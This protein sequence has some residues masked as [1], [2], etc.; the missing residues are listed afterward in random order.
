[1]NIDDD[2]KFETLENDF[3]G[4]WNQD[5]LDFC[6]I[7]NMYFPNSSK[8][9]EMKNHLPKLVHNYGSRQDVLNQ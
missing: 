3:G 2:N 1:M 5:I 7:C 8:L 9:A 4:L 6:Y